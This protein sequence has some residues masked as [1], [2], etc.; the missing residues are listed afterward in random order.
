M[1]YA[2]SHTFSEM[3][4]GIQVNIYSSHFETRSFIANN[5]KCR[6]H[7]GSLELDCLNL[8]TMAFVND[9]AQG[10]P[11][12]ST[13]EAS[14]RKCQTSDPGTSLPCFLFNHTTTT[15]RSTASHAWALPNLTQPQTMLTTKMTLKTF[16]TDNPTI[17]RD[18]DILLLYSS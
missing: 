3:V 7:T 18:A 4:T 6:M 2:S 11:L 1:S 8:T 10:Q 12:F 5:L 9:R 17:V 16:D 13:V 14:N 15:T